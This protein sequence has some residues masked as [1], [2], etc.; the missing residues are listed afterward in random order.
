MNPH[1]LV[2]HV[3][4]QLPEDLEDLLDDDDREYLLELVRNDY[5]GPRLLEIAK[6]IARSK[7]RKQK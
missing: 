6:Q 2:A 1:D 3:L 5:S 4:S 7:T